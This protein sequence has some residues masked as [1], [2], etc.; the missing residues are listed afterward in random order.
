MDGSVGVRQR[1]T[2]LES[3]L[4]EKSRR[5]LVA[6]ESKA[7]GPGGISAVSKTT[8][9]SRQVI[10]QGLRELEQSATHPAGRIRRP[11]GGRKKAKQKAPTLVADLEKLV[12]PTTRGDPETCLRWTCKSVRKPAEILSFMGHEV[13]YP[14]VAELLHEMGYILQANRKT[15]EGDSHPDRNAQFEYIKARV[16]Q[17]IGRRQPVI[18]VDTKKKELVGDFKNS[19]RDWRPPGE[20]EEVRVHDFLIKELGRAVP[21]GI[22]DLA[23]NAGWVSVGMSRDTSAF[24]VQTIRR[25]WQ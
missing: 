6:A 21:Y 7:W 24:A 19:G 5:L 2:V 18:S 23:S 1:F 4:D 22:Y 16:Q 8:G 11:V 10:R 3:V 14:V 15:K 20:P 9:V 25:W 13:S 12:E 17:Y